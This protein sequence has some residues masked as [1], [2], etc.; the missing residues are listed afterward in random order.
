M[1]DHDYI[2]K[3]K[4]LIRVALTD[5]EKG[6]FGVPDRK[7]RDGYLSFLLVTEHEGKIRF[8]DEPDLMY[9]HHG[10]GPI[11]DLTRRV[12]S[13]STSFRIEARLLP[14]V[15]GRYVKVPQASGWDMDHLARLALRC[16]S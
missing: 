3:R 10:P 8:R 6:R 1:S 14:M 5:S 2:E 9:K 16:V 11:P 15:E 4:E 7:L 12:F 13:R